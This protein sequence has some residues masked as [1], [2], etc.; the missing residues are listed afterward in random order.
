MFTRIWS[1][2]RSLVH[3][4]TSATPT[5]SDEDDERSFHTERKG[6]S[7][8]V[9]DTEALDPLENE[10]PLC[11]RTDLWS[12]IKMIG[13]RIRKAV[14]EWQ[15]R[16]HNPL[17]MIWPYHGNDPL[18]LVEEDK[19]DGRIVG[20]LLDRDTG[21]RSIAFDRTFKQLR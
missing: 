20:T 4:T 14:R 9:V 5:P 1:F 16:T 19:G 12:R 17:A 6:N 8:L 18:D 7:L 2:L 15:T 11:E 3:R 13:W 21:K 10:V